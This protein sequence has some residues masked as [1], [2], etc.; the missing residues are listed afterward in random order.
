MPDIPLQPVI[1][2]AWE[3]KH[4]IPTSNLL[5][6]T[7]RNPTASGNEHNT[8]A[9]RLEF[10]CRHRGVC[11]GLAGYFETV[12]YDPA[13][14]LGM[15]DTLSSSSPGKPKVELSTNPLTMDR[16]SRDMIS[17]FPMFLPLRQPLYFPD[18][19]VLVVHMWRRTE[20]RS[21]WYEWCVESFKVERG[22]G[23]K[24]RR[25]RLGAS[26]VVSSKASACLM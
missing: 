10:A 23:G 21:V 18:E 3:F 5:L 7:Q 2:E 25:V 12:L 20:G 4:P 8:R 6:P 9:T 24:P 17:W 13:S 1:R 22:R 16:K 15:D 14:V 19:C 26:D 11:H